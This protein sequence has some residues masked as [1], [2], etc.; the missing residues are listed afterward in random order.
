MDKGK[1]Q[2]VKIEEQEDVEE[3]FQQDAPRSV[4]AS[5]KLEDLDKPD[6][7]EDPWASYRLGSY[8]AMWYT[9]N[10]AYNYY[11]KI[12]C[13]GVDLHLTLGTYQLLVGAVYGGMYY[14][15]GLRTAPIL[16][17]EDIKIL[18]PIAF[19]HGMGH[20]AA[21]VALGAGAV[22]F[23]QIVKSGEPV[24]TATIS[25]LWLHQYFKWP[26]YVALIPIIMGV[27]IASANEVGFAW[28][29]FAGAM[30]SNLSFS[31]RAILTKRTMQ[32][33]VGENMDTVN[34]FYVTTVL[35]FLL[36]LPLALV[37]EGS[38]IYHV[39]TEAMADKTHSEE[40][41]WWVQA[42]LSGLFFYIYNEVAFLALHAVHPVTHAVANTVKR[43]AIIVSSILLFGNPVTFMG[44]LGCVV[45]ILGTLVYS[46]AKLHYK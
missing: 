18:A 32:K 38:E 27:A 13:M 40:V 2:Y 35:A 12:A 46:L 36:S 41:W 10:I 22:S 8:F 7:E 25:A 9:F 33:P 16:N 26:V 20:V 31:F 37:V 21:V 28:L 30:L 43:V 14:L 23:A 11:N 3:G 42:T 39:Y 6:V 17:W 45:A 44:S 24:F 1:T 29:A 5:M 4:K 34:L 15:F 19:C